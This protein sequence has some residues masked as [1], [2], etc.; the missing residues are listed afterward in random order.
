MPRYRPTVF[1]LVF[2][3][4]FCIMSGREIRGVPP[5]A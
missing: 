4:P 1:G 5:T 3:L 2:I